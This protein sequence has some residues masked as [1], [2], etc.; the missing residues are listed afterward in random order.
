MKAYGYGKFPN[1]NKLPKVEE[2]KQFLKSIGKKPEELNEAQRRI[3]MEFIERRRF[4]RLLKAQNGNFVR[5]SWRGIQITPEA[6]KKGFFDEN[7]NV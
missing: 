2:L 7:D 3:A 4:I 6:L 1:V 5:A